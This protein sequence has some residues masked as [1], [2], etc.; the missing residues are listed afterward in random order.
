MQALL[1]Q[2]DTETANTPHRSHKTST[3]LYLAGL[4]NRRCPIRI[5][6]AVPRR[7]ACLTR[8]AMLAA[9]REA[10]CCDRFNGDGDDSA[11]VMPHAIR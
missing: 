5:S 1:T 10:E 2:Q 8:R 9:L 3:C 6:F 4:R 7:E 11:D